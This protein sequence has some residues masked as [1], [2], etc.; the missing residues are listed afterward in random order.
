MLTFDKAKK[1][2]SK[3]ESPRQGFKVGKAAFLIKYRNQYAVIKNNRILFTL[4]KDNVFK[5]NL[6]TPLSLELVNKLTPARLKLIKKELFLGRIP[7]F[8]GM[9]IDSRGEFL[10]DQ[11]WSDKDQFDLECVD[12]GTQYSTKRCRACTQIHTHNLYTYADEG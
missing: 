7:F 12:C 8:Q 1:L 6:V 3:A 4:S 5:F 9:R 10:I 11:A 2:F